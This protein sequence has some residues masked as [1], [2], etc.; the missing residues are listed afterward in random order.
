MRKLNLTVIIFDLH[1]NKK[2]EKMNI[3]VVKLNKINIKHK[4]NKYNRII[5]FVIFI[6]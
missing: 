1:A 2:I 3:N 5:K 6:I 4:T